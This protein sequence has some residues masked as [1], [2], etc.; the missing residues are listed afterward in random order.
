MFVLF[1]FR[2]LVSFLWAVWFWFFY[3]CGCVLVLL[4][5]LLFVR[6][7]FV[8]LQILVWC[9]RFIGHSVCVLS[10]C[11]MLLRFICGFHNLLFVLT[12][13]SMGFVLP[14]W[15]WFWLFCNVTGCVVGVECYI[16]FAKYCY[17]YFYM[18]TCLLFVSRKH[19]HNSHTPMW[20]PCA[21]SYVSA[22]HGY[23]YFVPPCTFSSHPF[24]TIHTR[25]FLFVSYTFFGDALPLWKK[26]PSICY[27]CSHSKPDPPRLFAL[28]LGR[29]HASYML[30]A[31]HVLK[32]RNRKTQLYL[33]NPLRTRLKW[34]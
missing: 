23:P 19:T 30:C 16:E 32:L 20:I 27:V 13:L 29:M 4:W 14:V 7:C 21:S 11:F 10:L 31:V 1:F 22:P 8:V 17:V 9:T 26:V 15:P 5:L 18:N 6:V 12:N 2:E 33:L 3:S 25:D 34:I 28:A 24:T